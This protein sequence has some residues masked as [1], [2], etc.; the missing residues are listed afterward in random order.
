FMYDALFCA[1]LFRTFNV[2]D[3]FNYEALSIENNLNLPASQ[4]VA[5]LCRIAENHVYPAMIRMDY[6]QEFFDPT[7]TECAEKHVVKLEI[8]QSG[9]LAQNAFIE[10]FNRTYRTKILGFCLFRTLDEKRELA[11]NWLSEYNSERHINHLTI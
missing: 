4:V 11:A 7:R 6:G 1:R 9:K 5:V 3:D 8:T 2:V 10:S